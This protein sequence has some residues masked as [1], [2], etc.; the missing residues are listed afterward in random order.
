MAMQMICDLRQHAVDNNV[1]AAILLLSRSS[2][3]LQ[4]DT[5]TTVTATFLAR[6]TC[7]GVYMVSYNHCWQGVGFVD[8]R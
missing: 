8:Y 6:T 4:V 7:C 1:G 2:M 5:T 3:M